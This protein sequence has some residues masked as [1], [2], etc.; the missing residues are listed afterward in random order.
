M[1]AGKAG[2]Q[3]GD[4][5]SGFMVIEMLVY[6][7]YLG[8]LVIGLA[9]LLDRG[10]RWWGAATLAGLVLEFL[11]PYGGAVAFAAFGLCL[12]AYGLRRPVPAGH[13]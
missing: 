4:L 5:P 10:V 9:F 12:M 2:Q 3:R 6:V 13:A 7:F 1:T 11:V 8:V